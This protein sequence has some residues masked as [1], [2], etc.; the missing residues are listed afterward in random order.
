LAVEDVAALLD[1]ARDQHVAV[2]PEQILAVES[3]LPD[4]PE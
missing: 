1:T 3:R 4:L 2:D